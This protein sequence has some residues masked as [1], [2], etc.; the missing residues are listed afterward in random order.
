MTTHGVTSVPTPYDC[1]EIDRWQQLLEDGG[2]PE[3]RQRFERHLESCAACQTH[4]DRPEDGQ[5][6]DLLDWARR[7]GDPTH[8]PADPTLL[9]VLK[10]LHEVRSPLRPPDGPPDLYFLRPCDRPDLLGKLDEF[11]IEKVVGQGGMGVVLK[12]FEPA[13]HRL[14]AIKVLS[15][16]LAGSATARARFTREAKAA[17]AV[18]HDHIVVVHGVHEAEGLPYIVMEYIAGESLQERLD[19]TG[20]LELAE[21]V[22][23]GLQTASGLAAAHAQGLIHRDIKPANLLLENG[24]ARVSITDFGLARTA[25]DVGLTQHGVVSGTPQYMAPEQARADGIDHRSDLFSL[26]S[27]LYAMCT[28]RAPFRG[29]TTLAVLRQVSDETPTAIRSL[30]PDAPAWLED[31]I[32]RLMAKNP[33]ERFQ[34][35]AE[36]AC[37][38]EG[39]LAHLRQP[40]TVAVPALPVTAFS[41]NSEMAKREP[42]AG[43]VMQLAR[44]FGLPALGLLAALALVVFLL[45]PEQFDPEQQT[46]LALEQPE[47]TQPPLIYQ[48]FRKGVPFAYHFEE[49]GADDEAKI[50]SQADGLHIVVPATRQ[51]VDPVGVQ[52]SVNVAGDFEIITSYQILHAEQPTEGH[53]VGFELYLTTQT[54]ETEGLG[55]ARLS[56]VNEGESYVGTLLTINEDGTENYSCHFA[57]AKGSSGQLRIVRSG[58]KVT[59]FAAEADGL[60]RKLFT[61]DLGSENLKTIRLAAFPG[62]AR[63]A[64]DIRILDLRVYTSALPAARQGS[65]AE[66]K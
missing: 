52:L 21:I 27:V 31:L 18:C 41:G 48:D 63:N 51:A 50:K 7:V 28:G 1:P 39:Y 46:Q 22:R 25:D 3:E 36:V 54:H 61:H 65:R 17:A 58:T 13:L 43:G 8:A 4:L 42:R 2:A 34:S 12:A 16:S 45:P 40:T 47:H 29:S 10:L 49:I 35:A 38:L 15:P 60:F 44:R 6:D 30:N 56:R 53:G 23:I 37:L 64:V 62:W 55:L 66:G 57:E 26:G 20:P 59:F 19:R 24:L 5:R 32:A 14:V 9:R 33:D 11:E